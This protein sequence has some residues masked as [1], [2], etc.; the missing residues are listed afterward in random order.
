MR[1]WS[2]TPGSCVIARTTAF[3]R[4]WSSWPG[5]RG[6]PTRSSPGC[7]A[8]GKLPASLDDVTEVPIPVNP[9]TGKAFGYR[10]EGDTAVLEAAGPK[11]SRPRQYR[12]KL[13]E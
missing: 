7:T 5:S 4:P 9:F 10:L 6:R 8:D 3:K 13:A 11:I 1:R 2:C 12:L